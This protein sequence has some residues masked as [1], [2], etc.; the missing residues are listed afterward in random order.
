[1]IC[2]NCSR[3]IKEG[4]KFCQY[5]GASQQSESDVS[6]ISS[7][8]LED[9]PIEKSKQNSSGKSKTKIIIVASAIVVVMLLLFGNIHT[10]ERCNNTYMGAMYYDS[11]NPDETMCEDCAKHYYMG[12]D[13]TRFKVQ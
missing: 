6:T 8:S 12:L 1:M 13:Y 4:V 10:C 3:E 9:Y 11:W 2:S 7:F 5:C